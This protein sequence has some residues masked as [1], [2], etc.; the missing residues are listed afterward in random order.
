MPLSSTQRPIWH[1]PATPAQFEVEL[2]PSRVATLGLQRRVGAAYPYILTEF[3]VA[4]DTG[5]TDL[6]VVSSPDFVYNTH[7][8]VPLTMYYAGGPVNGTTGIHECH[9]GWFGRYYR[10]RTRR[11]PGSRI[12]H[13]R[14]LGSH[15]MLTE[16]LG[17]VKGLPFHFNIF[18]QFPALDNFIGLSLSRPEDPTSHSGDASFTFNEVDHLYSHIVDT[19][20]IPLFPGDN[21][22]WRRWSVV[23]DRIN[24]DGQDILMKSVVQ[25]A[26]KVALVALI[27]SGTPQGSLPPDVFYALYLRIPGALFSGPSENLDNVEFAIPYNTTTTIT[28]FIARTCST[29]S[30]SYVDFRMIEGKN[31]RGCFSSFYPVEP[32]FPEDAF[33]GDTFMRNAYSIFNFGSTVAKSPTGNASIQLLSQ[34]TEMESVMDVFTARMQQL[35]PPGYPPVYVGDLPGYTPVVPGNAMPSAPSSSSFSSAV[36]FASADTAGGGGGSSS[37]KGVID[38]AAS[39]DS[40][41]ANAS[42]EHY[43]PIIVGLLGGNLVVLLVLAALGVALYARRGGKIIA[44]TGGTYAGPVK[45][46]EEDTD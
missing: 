2:A 9:I 11:T 12:H 46:R 8:S 43:G 31:V 27:D 37:G 28:V 1:I 3:R 34:T 29:R 30:T 26:P 33:F 19:V 16:T 15:S 21:G 32:G 22:R 24:V 18:D 36:P 39:N 25:K 45:L 44:R 42:A 20:P 14:I 40:A 5:S 35:P 4:V 7:E 10:C 38:L 17:P 41:N 6:W 13:K 23:V